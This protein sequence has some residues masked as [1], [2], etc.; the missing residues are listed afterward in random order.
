MNSAHHTSSSGQWLQLFR[1]P[2]SILCPS[3]FFFTVPANAYPL[4]TFAPDVQFDWHFA[5]WGIA[6]R[7]S[8]DRLA[9]RVW[10][11]AATCCLQRTVRSPLQSYCGWDTEKSRSVLSAQAHC[12]VQLQT[13]PLTFPFYNRANLLEC[14]RLLI[15]HLVI[16]LA[17]K[18]TCLTRSQITVYTEDFTVNFN[19]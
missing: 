11:L 12:P 4:L 1:T 14:I 6:H 7:K 16:L 3:L 18:L 9:T 8:H 13:M 10:L 19:N 2:S 5:A 17:W 15:K